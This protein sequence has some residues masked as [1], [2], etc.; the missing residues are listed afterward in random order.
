[1]FRDVV[2]GVED[3]DPVIVIVA[4]PNRP[5][6]VKIWTLVVAVPFA[7]SDRLL[8]PSDANAQTQEL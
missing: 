2:N 3:D 7:G 5:W 6:L 8:D 1:M 4:L